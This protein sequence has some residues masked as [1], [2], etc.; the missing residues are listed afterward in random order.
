VHA[1]LEPPAREDAFNQII[2][3]GADASV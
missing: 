1:A 2:E 3:V